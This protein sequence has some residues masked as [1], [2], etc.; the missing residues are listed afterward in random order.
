MREVLPDSFVEEINLTVN[1]STLRKV[2]GEQRD[3]RYI[4][5]IAKRG[6]RFVVPV[7]GIPQES[8]LLLAKRTSAQILIREE[9]TE[10]ESG[11]EKSEGRERSAV[12]GVLSRSRVAAASAI[13]VALLVIVSAAVSIRR[14]TPASS[15]APLTPRQLDDR[16]RVR[17]AFQMIDDEGRGEEAIPILRDVL[18]GDPQNAMAHWS[19]SEAYRYGGMLDESIAEGELAIRLDP[20]VIEE[21]TFNAYF[22]A[23]Q[24]EKFISSTQGQADFPRTNFYR[25]LVYLYLKNEARAVAEFDRAY[26]LAPASF[27]ARLGQAFKAAIMDDRANGVKI[28]QELEHEN[29]PPDGELFY[30]VAQAY[31]LLGDKQSALRVLRFSIERNFFCLPYMVQDS[32]LQSLRKEP[33]YFQL[34]DQAGIRHE[35]FKRKFF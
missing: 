27:H 30:K 15:N 2:L 24:Y 6:Y 31:A 22:Y 3:A 19:L 8:E 16:E 11:R 32:F 12:I 18:H 29:V 17:I 10:E 25:G 20:K 14:I 35:A 33:E 26:E 34:T 9:E 28:L 4:E 21:T 13:A 1:I 5:T 23:G 7:R